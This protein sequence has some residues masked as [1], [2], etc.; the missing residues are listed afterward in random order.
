MVGDIMRIVVDVNHPADY[1][2]FKN[3]VS[4][5]KKRGHDILITATQKDV[6]LKLLESSG[7]D[8]VDLGSYGN[9][10]IRKVLSVPV[11]DLKMYNAVK[12]FDPDILLGLGSIRAPHVSFILGK[13]SINL[14]DTEIA[15]Q[16]MILRVP[17]VSTVW[18]PA[19]FKRDIGNKQIRYDGYKELAYLHPRYFIPDRQVLDD[20][21][22]ND[23]DII[24]ILRFVSWE[25]THDIGANGLK[26][27][28]AAI[29]ELEK[30]GR[31]LITSEAYLGEDLEK[32]RITVPPDRLHDLLYYATIYIGEG[33]TMAT[34][35]A[36]LG[37]PSIYLSS[38]K[39]KLGSITE[40]SQKYNLLY[41]FD[42]QEEAL[43]K[44]IELIGTPNVKKAWKKKRNRLLRE[45]IDVTAYM[46]WFVENYPESVNILKKDPWLQYTLK[47]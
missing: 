7:F 33:A 29:S 35:A 38:I 47:G 18:T 39:E 9:S 45:K 12:K 28:L 27:K 22:L 46:V 43:R 40:L 11:I 34:E 5:L 30:F 20:L 14:E 44:A 31:V 4:K 6:S 23:D 42:D 26:D 24:I 21:G 19:C 13:N 15:S 36:I 8:Y 16:Q 17:F 3:L 10:L 32:Y 2:Y 41:C 37:T 25:S 1:H